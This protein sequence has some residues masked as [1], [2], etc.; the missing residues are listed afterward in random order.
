MSLVS[1]INI[2]KNFWEENPNFTVMGPFQK[3]RKN[4]KSKGKED[5]SHMMWAIC[6]LLDPGKSNP[7]RNLDMDN[8]KSLINDYMFKKNKIDWEDEEVKE[9]VQFYKDCV[10]TQ[11]EKSLIAW[12]TKMKERDKVLETT[13]YTLMNRKDIEEAMINTPKL[14]TEYERLR[15]RIEQDNDKKA[16][17]SKPVALLDE[18]NF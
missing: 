17:K 15:A 14:Y 1:D 6:F 12:D 10:L 3:L 4:D 2:M 11:P 8:K 13:P 5:S 16:G 18:D 9:I 7:Y